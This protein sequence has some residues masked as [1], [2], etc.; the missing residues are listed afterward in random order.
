MLGMHRS[1]TSVLTEL[2][3]AAGLHAGARHELMPP[4]DDNRRGYFE[5]TRLVGMHDEL[6]VQL[7][8]YWHAPPSRPAALAADDFDFARQQLLALLWE[9]VGR[10]EPWVLKD[11]RLCTLWH[12]YRPAFDPSPAIVVMVRH[13]AAVASSLHRRDGMPADY[14]AV[15]WEHHVRESLRIAADAPSRTVVTYEQLLAEP[16]ATIDAVVDRLAAGGLGVR[17]VSPRAVAEVVQAGLRRQTAGDDAGWIDDEQLDLWRMVQTFAA[18]AD[19]E[20]VAELGDA[21]G[22]RL[23]ERATMVH[24][25]VTALN[26]GKMEPVPLPRPL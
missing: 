26:A 14:A 6:L 19:I 2:L 10:S 18:G 11:P 23:D 4:T 8:R 7:R 9:I 12:L 13:P 17:P 3:I 16:Q 25:N 22:R 15:L 24:D 20:P 21:K 5:P 1:G